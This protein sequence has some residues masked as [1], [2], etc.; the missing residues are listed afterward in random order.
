LYLVG[1]VTMSYPVISM[2]KYISR[3]FQLHCAEHKTI[4]AF[5]AGVPLEVAHI[6][7]QSTLHPRCGTGFLLAVMIVSVFV[8]SLVGRP[9]L[10]WLILSRLLLVPVIAMVAYECIRFLG[11]HRRNPIVK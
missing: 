9:A 7:T 6:R 2:H 8:F 1:L 4:N 3:D 5:E 11:R 10:V